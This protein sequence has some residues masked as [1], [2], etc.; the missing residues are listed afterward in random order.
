MPDDGAEHSTY[1]TT[2]HKI[3]IHHSMQKMV[4]FV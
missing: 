2:F 1:T 3:F 4:L